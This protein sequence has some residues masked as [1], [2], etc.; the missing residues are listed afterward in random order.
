[1]EIYG[2]NAREINNEELNSEET[3]S[4]E[5]TAETCE[6][7]AIDILLF[8]RKWGIWHGTSIIT[9]GNEYYYSENGAYKGIP[10][11]SVEYGV[12]PVEKCTS[13]WV[14]APDFA[15]DDPTVMTEDWGG[16]KHTFDIR[17]GEELAEL[18]NLFEYSVDIVDLS[19]E[20]LNIMAEKYNLFD[21]AV[22]KIYGIETIE[23]LTEMVNNDMYDKLGYSEPDPLYRKQV[24]KEREDD[25]YCDWDPLVYDTFEEYLEMNEYDA[26]G[27]PRYTRYETYEQYLE[28]MDDYE[29]VRVEEEELKPLWGRLVADAKKKYIEKCKKNNEIIFNYSRIANDLESEFWKLFAGY[30]ICPELQT[31]YIISAG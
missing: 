3:N 20:A 6:K 16:P 29:E 23:E 10:H 21:E 1:M 22:K 24:L 27:E 31:P 18:L 5:M 7:L 26:Y 11:I 17:L 9:N 19:D 30:P 28:H 15:F 12:D 2:M 4:E 14:M 25:M 13:T 8:L